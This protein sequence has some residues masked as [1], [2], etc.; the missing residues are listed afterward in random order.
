MK[1]KELVMDPDKLMEQV[2]T[3]LKRTALSWLDAYQK[4]LKEFWWLMVLIS[5][6]QT[7]PSLGKFTQ[8]FT[9]SSK[10]AKWKNNN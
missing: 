4:L 10:L 5:S 6:L 9:A 7:Q 1:E 3:F 8:I 2:L